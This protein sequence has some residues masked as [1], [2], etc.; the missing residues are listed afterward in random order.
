MKA[1]RMHRSLERNTVDDSVVYKNRS[2]PDH[3]IFH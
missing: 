1:G 3:E 2:R